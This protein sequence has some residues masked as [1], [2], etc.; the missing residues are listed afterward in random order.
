MYSIPSSGTFTFDNYEIRVERG[1]AYLED[2]VLH[3]GFQFR[4]KTK[5]HPEGT[6][7]ARVDRDGT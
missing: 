4:R 7:K 5:Q 6:Q 2:L 1:E 3:P